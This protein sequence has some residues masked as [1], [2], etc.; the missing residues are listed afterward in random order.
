MSNFTR[1][2]YIL[3]FTCSYHFQ[4]PWPYFKVF[5]LFLFNK[6]DSVSLPSKA[7][8]KDTTTIGDTKNDT[9]TDVNARISDEVFTE[10]SYPSTEVRDTADTVTDIP[11]PRWTVVR[12][13]ADTLPSSWRPA[14]AVPFHCSFTLCVCVCV[15][16]CVCAVS[17]THLTLPTNAEV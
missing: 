17:Y 16:V 7:K 12:R 14:R 3:S 15:C 1:C 9:H 11:L 4:W 10:H 13:V 6:D 5:F 2:Y 8:P